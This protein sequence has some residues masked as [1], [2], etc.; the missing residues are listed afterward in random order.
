MPL[1]KPVHLC[2]ETTSSLCRYVEQAICVKYLC[3]EA[4]KQHMNLGT[5]TTHGHN[6]YITENSHITVDIEQQ[7]RA[8]LL[9]HDEGSEDEDLDNVTPISGA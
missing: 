8:K 6:L 2:T 5:E 4:N 3:T 9:D 1:V 7:I